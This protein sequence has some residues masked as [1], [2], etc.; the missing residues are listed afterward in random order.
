MP[1][2]KTIYVM[3][4]VIFP[5]HVA[6]CETVSDSPLLLQPILLCSSFV[7]KFNFNEKTVLPLYPLPVRQD[8]DTL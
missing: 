4:Q 6:L 5:P 2:H 3:A 1:V 7:W 8:H